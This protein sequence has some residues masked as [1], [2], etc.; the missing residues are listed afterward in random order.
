MLYS[1]RSLSRSLLA[2]LAVAPLLVADLA[3][4]QQPTSL[5]RYPTSVVE[6]YLEGCQRQAVSAGIPESL[7]KNF[8]SCTLN[9]LRSRYTVEEFRQLRD[10]ATTAS[11]TPQAFTEVGMACFGELSSLSN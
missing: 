5:N 7:V 1:F 9:K 11:E 8:C 2:F 10:R 4:A 6:D 3:K